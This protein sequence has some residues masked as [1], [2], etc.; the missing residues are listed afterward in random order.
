[1]KISASGLDMAAKCGEQYRFRYIE[2]LKVPPSGAAVIGRA[3]HYGQAHNL[4]FKR[5]GRACSTEEVQDVTRARFDNEWRGDYMHEEEDRY[6][7]DTPVLLNDDERQRA[8]YELRGIYKDSAGRLATAHA[9]QLAPQIWPAAV[10]QGFEVEIPIEYWTRL[11]QYPVTLRGYIDVIQLTQDNDGLE[12]GPMVIR[13]T[14]NKPRSIGGWGKALAKGFAQHEWLQGLVYAL[15]VKATTGALPRQLCVDSVVDYAKGPQTATQTLTVTDADL[16]PV[17]S[18]IES[19][20]A[21]RQS[22]VFPPASP[23]WWGCSKKWCGYW[24]RCRYAKRP[25]SSGSL[26]VLQ[27]TWVD[28]IDQGGEQNG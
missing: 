26:P 2:G 24:D 19:V 23:S 5:Q 1:M 25:V 8:R 15:A 27:G 3:A 17:I 14:K 13:D 28:K 21:M 20:L 7:V 6:T 18:R 16:V 12:E 10:E 4:E 11:A 22:G 9:E